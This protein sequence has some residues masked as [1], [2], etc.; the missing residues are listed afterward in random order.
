[1][2]Y[3]PKENQENREKKKTECWNENRVE[4]YKMRCQSSQSNKK[5]GPRNEKQQHF[6]SVSNQNDKPES[7]KPQRIRRNRRN[8][9]SDY[10][11][12]TFTESQTET[13][14][15]LTPRH[16]IVP[17]IRTDSRVADSNID[18]ESQSARASHVTFQHSRSETPDNKPPLTENKTTDDN[19]RSVTINDQPT[20]EYANSD[21]YSPRTDRDQ[22]WLMDR[23]EQRSKSGGAAATRARTHRKV[24]EKNYQYDQTRPQTA[25]HVLYEQ[26]G[27]QRRSHTANS[28]YGTPQRSTRYMNYNFDKNMYAIHHQNCYIPTQHSIDIHNAYS[29]VSG[30]HTQV[31]SLLGPPPVPR[32]QPSVYHSSAFYYAPGRYPTP[33]KPFPPRR[34]QSRQSFSSYHQQPPEFR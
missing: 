10:N 32:H 31:R 16:N 22:Q 15:L 25:P 9:K 3:V 18:T 17:P 7:P 34:S 12:K 5:P 33:S 23:Y 8:K 24:K 26:Y 4:V 6:D 1:M 27:P 14:D 21:I 30:P 19:N 2:V 20:V 13:P 29:P 28:S 11:E